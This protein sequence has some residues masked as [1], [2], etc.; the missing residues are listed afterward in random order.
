MT[1]LH[2]RSHPPSANTSTRLFLARPST[3]LICAIG[4]EHAKFK[5]GFA[6]I[7]CRL[8]MS[9]RRMWCSAAPSDRRSER[10]R[11][12]ADALFSAA[13]TL[14]D[15]RTNYLFGDWSIPDV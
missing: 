1:A 15:G 6:A 2:C 14:L 12:A 8:A 3:L 11:D 10:A 4:R 5:L 9:A 7:S 13:L